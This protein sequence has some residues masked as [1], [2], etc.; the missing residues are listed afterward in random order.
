MF[1]SAVVFV[2][3][4]VLQA[5]AHIPVYTKPHHDLMMTSYELIVGHH[6]LIIRFLV[7][8]DLNYILIDYDDVC[9]ASEPVS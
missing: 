4:V 7:D 9:R 6:K 2:C 5:V 8:W 1:N 3:E